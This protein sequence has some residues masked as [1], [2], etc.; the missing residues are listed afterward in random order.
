MLASSVAW[1]A[2]RRFYGDSRHNIIYIAASATDRALGLDVVTAL[3]VDFYFLAHSK[4]LGRV[5]LQLRN[6]RLHEV[7]G[8]KLNVVGVVAVGYR[9]E[10]RLDIILAETC[11]RLQSLKHV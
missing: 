5:G 7:V 4:A 9:K 3:Q 6:V 11:Q 10:H 1:P 8:H 2:T